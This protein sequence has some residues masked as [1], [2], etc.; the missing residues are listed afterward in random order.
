M[1]IFSFVVAVLTCLSIVNAQR[2]G[3]SECTNT[4]LNTYAGKYT[5]GARIAYMESTGKTEEEAC[6]RVA[7]TEFPS[8]CGPSC[9]PALC[10]GRLNDAGPEMHCGCLSCTKDKWDAITD[11][12]SCGA[13]ISHLTDAMGYS[14]RNACSLVAG[15]QFPSICGPFCDPDLCEAIPESTAGPTLPPIP[16]PTLE[17]TE[18]PSLRP[19]RLPTHEPS[20]LPTAEALATNTPVVSPD[21]PS[22]TIESA[23]RCG[24]Y[25]CTE[26]VWNAIAD[27]YTCGA[28]ILYV[29]GDVDT[30]DAY[31]T[32]EQA[33]RLVAGEQFPDICGSACDPDS[34]DGRSLPSNSDGEP[35]SGPNDSNSEPTARCG[36]ADCTA[37]LWNTLVAGYS[38]GARIDY[39]ATYTSEYP[40]EED[41]CRQ[42]AGVEFPSVCGPGCNPDRCD[43]RIPPPKPPLTPASSLYCFPEYAQRTRFENVWGKYTVEVKEGASC[44]PGD[45]K[46]TTNTVSVDNDELRLQFKKV[47][48]SWEG[49]EVRVILPEEEMPYTYGKYSFSVKS[50][51][52]LDADT[53]AVIDTVL[54]QSLV[55]GLF[56]WDDTENYVIHENWNHEVD[57]EISRWNKPGDPDTQFLVQPPL[58]PHYERFYSGGG[59]TYD[60]GGHVYEFTWNPGKVTWYTDA[61]GGTNHSYATEDAIFM[62]LNDNVQCLPANVEVRLNLWNMFGNVMPVGMSAIQ[63]AEVVIDDFTFTPSNLEYVMDGGYCTK[64]CQCDASST[65][66]SG[67]CLPDF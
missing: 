12:Y 34:C 15:E 33:C 24:C 30:F 66:V 37:T 1:T 55:L 60:Q 54:P 43:G 17:P 5:C 14:T 10:D 45:N 58:D 56:T 31:T 21:G 19:A 7:G 41:A 4:V 67:I 8:I 28:R 2:C 59:S 38:C 42:V 53:S 46:F 22:S 65:C 29:T 11:V 39:V 13:R 63:V 49:S 57:V 48:N 3:C 25:E 9:D 40:T 36:C 61:A 26:Q 18:S 64:P 32:E 50:V 62:G 23:E 16:G 51:S 6:S 35:I 20:L 47:A 44:G 52:V 27:K